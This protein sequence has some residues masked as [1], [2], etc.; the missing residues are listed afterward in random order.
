MEMKLKTIKPI[1]E[2]T[3]ATVYLVQ[4]IITGKY[5]AKKVV[6]TSKMSKKL[7][8]YFIAEKLILRA[9][10]AYNFKNIIKAH[11]IEKLT[12]GDYDLIL[13][14]CNGGS[15]HECLYNYINRYRKPFPENIVRYLMEQILIGVECLHKFGIIHRDLKLGNILIKYN[16]ENDRINQN[17]LAAE[18]KIIDFNVS[19]FPKSSDPKTFLGTIPNMAPSV[20]KTYEYPQ[21]EEYDNKI[22]IWSLG[23]ICYEM[24]F[25]KPLFSNIQNNEN[26]NNI[27]NANFTIPETISPKARSFLYCMLQKDGINRLSCTQ[28]LNHEFIK[29]NFFI[30]QTS[31]YDKIPIINKNY[32]QNITN[33]IFNDVKGKKIN[34]PV[35]ENTKIQDV[36]RLYFHR[37]KRPELTHN[38][39]NKFSFL[40][41]GKNLRYSLNNTVK[42]MKIMSYCTIQVY[43]I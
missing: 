43:K 29:E 24:L 12:N 23:T 37:I 19:Y 18:I 38:Y 42:N 39:H 22:D 25:G 40:F 13:D 2:G 28:L 11:R 36:I 7:L 14:Y 30:D 8:H 15:L 9:S 1:G 41:N 20:I 10:I 6:K 31:D 3:F 17:I 16:N 34:I 35:D 21:I 32:N 27:I 4:D 33:I 5:Y 26:F